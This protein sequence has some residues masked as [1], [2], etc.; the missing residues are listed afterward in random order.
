MKKLLLSCCVVATGFA[1]AAP[2]AA[3][4]Q[5]TKPGQRMIYDERGP[6]DSKQLEKPIFN[7]RIVAPKA[8]GAADES[9]QPAGEG[10]KAA[11]ETS[12]NQDNVF[13][14]PEAARKAIEDPD[15]D[16]KER[17]DKDGQK[18]LD[19]GKLTSRDKRKLE[20][21]VSDFME[22]FPHTGVTKEEFEK[23]SVQDQQR[24]RDQIESYIQKHGADLQ[25][26]LDMA[27][28]DNAESEE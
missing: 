11:Q 12:G 3:Q 24:I 25:R 5:S 13:A 9:P 26:D 20:K 14:T 1:V 7:K 28:Q 10:G 8:P 4:A 17:A 2:I 23:M 18:E 22:D 21:K 16:L 15:S 6:A 27:K 19:I